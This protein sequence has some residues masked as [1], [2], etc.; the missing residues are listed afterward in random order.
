M[1]SFFAGS[2]VIIY[3]GALVSFV[4]AGVNRLPISPYAQMAI[5]GTLFFAP[6]V[7]HLFRDGI[8]EWIKG[9]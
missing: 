1:R 2:L 3:I 5:V 9:N 6:I 4:T 7:V 8:E